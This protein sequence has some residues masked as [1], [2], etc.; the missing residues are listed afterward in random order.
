MFVEVNDIKHVVVD[1]PVDL[2]VPESRW[3]RLLGA[4]PCTF[5]LD[6]KD[7]S[8]VEGRWKGRNLYRKQ[9]GMFPS[10]TGNLRSF[11]REKG[12][13]PYEVVYVTSGIYDIPLAVNARVGTVLLSAANEALSTWP[14]LIVKDVED[15]IEALLSCQRGSMRGYYGEVTATLQENGRPSGNRGTILSPPFDIEDQ[16]RDWMDVLA[17]G[18]YFPTGDDR[19]VKHQY[20]QRILAAK[21]ADRG[22]VLSRLLSSV[23]RQIDARFDLVTPVPPRPGRTSG[24]GLVVEEACRLAGLEALY[25]EAALVC[26]RNYRPQKEISGTERRGNVMGAFR[27]RLPKSAKHIIL[28][29]DVITSGATIAECARALIGAGADRVTAIVFGYTQRVV[30]KNVERVFRCTRPGC[31][32]SFRIRFGKSKGRPFWGCSNWPG[33]KN[34]LPWSEGL[35]EINRLNTVVTELEDIFDDVPF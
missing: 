24:Y 33:C 10:V 25:S 17:L 8:C 2:V 31:N 23:L 7:F 26:T 15:L 18:R 4:L 20:T 14:D 22:F 5:M 13:Q 27:S 9:P 29:D 35:R 28:V 1:L 32:G 16:L 3:V 34:T 11:M 19:A 12:L 21:N 30:S 6:P